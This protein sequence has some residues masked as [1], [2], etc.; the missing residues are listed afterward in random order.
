MLKERLIQLR[1]SN[2]KT[3]KEIASILGITRPAYTAY[4]RGNRSPDYDT[5]KKIADHYDV[6]TDFL[7]GHTDDPKEK[8]EEPKMF[9]YGGFDDMS[10]EEMQELEEYAQLMRKRRK[11]L[12]KLFK[13]DRDK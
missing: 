9:A 3:Q 7:L 8:E 10:E 11:R 12:E 1:K 5:L 13:E 6:S 2:K 4:E